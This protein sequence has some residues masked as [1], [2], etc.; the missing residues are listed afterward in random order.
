M[1][2]AWYPVQLKDGRRVWWERVWYHHWSASYL[3]TKNYHYEAIS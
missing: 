2:F 1:W 3:T